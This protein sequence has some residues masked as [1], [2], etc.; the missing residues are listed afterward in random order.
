MAATDRAYKTAK[1]QRRDMSLPEALLWQRLRRSP[2]GVSFRRQHPIGC[3]VLDFYC[4]AIKL[5]IEIDGIAHDMGERPERDEIRTA[6]L[7]A[8]GL[9]VMRIAARDV[10]RDPDKIAQA[11][12]TLCQNP[13]TTRYA[14]GSPPHSPGERGRSE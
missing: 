11:L 13:S 9:Q 10:L 8:Q 4:P 6:W 2:C 7:E 14:G 5:A 12:V 1:R 3:Y